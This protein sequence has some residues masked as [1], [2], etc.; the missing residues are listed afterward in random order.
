MKKK[1]RTFC[2]YCG[3]H[4]TRNSEEGIVRDFCEACN[5][6]FYENPLP[7]VSAIVVSDRKLLLVKRG[8]RPYKGRWCLP[9]GFAESGESIEE[10]ALREL[11]E[12]TGIEGKIQNLID[13][14]SCT[15]Y[16][17]GDLLFIAFEVEQTGGICLPGSDTVAVRYFP[18]EAIPRLAFPSNEHAVQTYIRTKAESWA[19]MDSFAGAIAEDQ[20]GKKGNL[21]SDRLVEVIEKNVEAI[22]WNWV[23]DAQTNVSTSAYHKI[24]EKKLFNNVYGILSKFC[25]WLRGHDGDVNNFYIKLGSDS[26]KKGFS[27]SETLSALSLVRR[28]IWDFALS[29]G[30]WQKTVDI[31]MVVELETRIILFFD[32][33]AFHTTRGYE[34]VS[35]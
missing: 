22:A 25:R 10:A 30:L 35:R 14:E 32:K 16:F 5:L 3:K 6:F 31:Y 23:R 18:I 20:Y 1:K 24:E 28:H 11:R 19:I 17:Y 7:V 27:L 13:V 29:R 33:A 26:R 21:L 8:K 12:E 2:P 4:I 15:S 9:T 34:R